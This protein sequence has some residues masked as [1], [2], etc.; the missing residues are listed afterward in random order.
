MIKKLF[1]VFS[2]VVCIFSFVGCMSVNSSGQ[3]VERINPNKQTDLSGYWN[4]TDVRIIA[5]TLVE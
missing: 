4:D 5:E 3:S 2:A 1:V